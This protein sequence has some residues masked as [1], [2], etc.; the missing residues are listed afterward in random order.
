M[1]EDGPE[2][3]RRQFLKG[4]GALI[5]T[6][7]PGVDA[8]GAALDTKPNLALKIARLQRDLA[9]GGGYYNALRSPSIMTSGTVES[10]AREMAYVSQELRAMHF[11]QKPVEPEAGHKYMHSLNI[12]GLASRWLDTGRRKVVD[13]REHI[14]GKS[15]NEFFLHGGGVTYEVAPH[16]CVANTLEEQEFVTMRETDVAL[17]RVNATKQR[18][19]RALVFDSR[20]TREAVSGWLGITVGEKDDVKDAW[21]GHLVPMTTEFYAYLVRDEVAQGFPPP[22]EPGAT[23][24]KQGF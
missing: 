15:C 8:L 21:Y 20:L 14:L 24:I 4:F 12:P 16:H 11:G 19:H 13:G 2:L 23:W 3:N 10:M 17:R 9:K 5:L 18:N 7:C 6:S 22:R 1:K